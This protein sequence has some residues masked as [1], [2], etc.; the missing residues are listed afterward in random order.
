MFQK[1]QERE[2]S[3]LPFFILSPHGKFRLRWDILSVALISCELL[4]RSRPMC[5]CTLVYLSPLTFSFSV[6]AH[7]DNA[8]IIPVWLVLRRSLV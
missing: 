3:T 4:I 8:T 7:S 1:E 2:E 5:Q 6:L